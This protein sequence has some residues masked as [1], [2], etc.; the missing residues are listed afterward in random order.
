L[1]TVPTRMSRF[2]PKSGRDSCAADFHRA[3]GKPAHRFLVI[4]FQGKRPAPACCSPVRRL[5]RA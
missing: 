4:K 5:C 2:G 3:L 1:A